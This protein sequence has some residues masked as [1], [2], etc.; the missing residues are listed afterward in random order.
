MIARLLPRPTEVVVSLFEQLEDVQINALR[1]HQFVLAGVQHDRHG[2]KSYGVFPQ[3][4]LCKVLD[5]VSSDRPIPSLSPAHCHGPAAD[6]RR[7][8]E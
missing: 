8:Q 6:T 2:D 5:V 7:W 1:G 4:W 3:A